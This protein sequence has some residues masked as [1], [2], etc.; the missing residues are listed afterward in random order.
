MK[1]KYLRYACILIGILLLGAIALLISVAILWGTGGYGVLLFAMIY[2]VVAVI[3]IPLAVTF[4]VLSITK[5][6]PHRWLAA[7]LLALSLPIVWRGTGLL[8]QFGEGLARDFFAVH[9]RQTP[10]DRANQARP[11]TAPQAPQTSQT[12]SSEPLK[13]HLKPPEGAVVS[14][15]PAATDE[16][17][18]RTDERK[19]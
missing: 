19:R 15:Q 18:A 12:P 17:K 13:I 8:F 10:H 1:A 4:L 7:C 5:R 16:Q 3:A 6:E 11:A 14:Q 9:D 2:A